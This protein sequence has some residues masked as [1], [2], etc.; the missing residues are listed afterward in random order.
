M[1]GCILFSRCA[2]LIKRTLRTIFVEREDP[3]SRMKAV[4]EIRRRTHSGGEWP[5][6]QL[7]PEGMPSFSGQY[8]QCMTGPQGAVV[9][10]IILFC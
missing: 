7:F 6:V 4:G 10:E 8:R 1:Y 9:M 5:K 3:N 2:A